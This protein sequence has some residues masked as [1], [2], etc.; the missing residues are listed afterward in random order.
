MLNFRVG[1]I[2]FVLILGGCASTYKNKVDF[3]P[4]EPIRVAVLPFYYVDSKGGVVENDADL[5]IDQ[6]GL[7]SSELEETPASF[8]RKAVYNELRKTS[9]DVLAPSLVD[10]R[11]SHTGFSKTDLTMDLKRIAATPPGEFCPNRSYFAIQSVATVSLELSLVSVRDGKVLYQAEAKDSE[12]RGI[13]KGPTGFSDLVVEPIRGLNNQII[14]DLARSMVVKSLAP[15]RAENRPEFLDSPPPSISASAHD[16]LQGD[17]NSSLTVIMLGNAQMS[18][19]FSIGNNLFVLPM[20]E[21][22]PG[23]YVGEYYP[24]PVDA[25]K[26][27][28]VT[29][30]LTDKFG[31][32]SA[33]RIGGQHVTLARSATISFKG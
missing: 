23:H 1:L 3:N 31:R 5:L 4:L 33:Q 29:V 20:S 16:A 8:V 24:L 22:E 2:S 12:S 27:Q 10:S 11:L 17:I 28:I 30:Y 18:A 19:S 26:D 25:F 13:T 21:R 6:V 14:Q 9:M 15:L 32:T 7:V